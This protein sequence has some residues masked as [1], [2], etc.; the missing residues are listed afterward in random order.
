MALGAKA[1]QERRRLI[2]SAAVDVLR[3]KG[4]AGARIADIAAVAGTSPALVV[5]HF[6]SL[7]GA[8]A[9]ALTTVEDAFYDELA[10]AMPPGADPPTRLRVLA[11]L[12]SQTGPALG[13]WALWMEV[14]VRALRDAQARAL[15]RALDARWRAALREILEAG[16][17]DGSWRCPD[18]AAT[19][20]RLAALMD[21]LAVQVALGDPDVPAGSMAA[22]WL[23]SASAE[24][25]VPL[26]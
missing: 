1:P 22:A 8:L 18:P 9:E 16:V 13:D 14:W 24:L 11:D 21:G 25:G 17:A 7:D 10:A 23:A 19:A 26:P 12:G 4:F 20:V 2:L 3:E 5:Y 6:G 15:R